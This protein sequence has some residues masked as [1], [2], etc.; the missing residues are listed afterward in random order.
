MDKQT[1]EKKKKELEKNY[2]ELFNQKTHFKIRIG[3][4]LMALMVIIFLM[5]DLVI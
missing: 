1:Y 3:L 2:P 4:F 5:N